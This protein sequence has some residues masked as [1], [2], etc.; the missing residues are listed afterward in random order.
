MTARHSASRLSS[1]D[2]SDLQELATKFYVD[3]QV[4][5]TSMTVSTDKTIAAGCC[6]IISDCYEV[7]SGIRLEIASGSVLE[8]T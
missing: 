7:A 1:L 6:L 4:G 8:I 3:S 5:P 2:P